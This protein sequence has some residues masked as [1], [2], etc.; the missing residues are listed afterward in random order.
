MRCKK[1]LNAAL[2][3]LAGVSA[4]ASVQCGAGQ[5]APGITALAL[6]GVEISASTGEKPQSKVWSHAGHWWAVLPNAAGTHL[7]RL[8]G[9]HWTPALHLSD[10]TDFHADARNVNG[11]THVFLYRATQSELVSLEY[12]SAA[13]TYRLW[14]MRPAPVPIHLD[15]GVETA[16]IDVDA[17]G[18][19]WLASDGVTDINVRWSDPPYAEW[20]APLTLA[21][22]VD[23]DDICVVTAFPNGDTGVLWSNQ[24]TK[25]FGFRVHPAG[26]APAAWSPDEAPASASALPVGDGMPDDHLNCAIAAE[27]TLYVA[28][29]TSYDTEGYTKIGL[30]LRRPSGEWD[31]LHHVD[32]AGT[33][34]IALLNEER[35][36]LFVVY[37]LSDAIVYR[38]SSLDAIAFG[39]RQT[40]ITK[41]SERVN[42]VTSTKQNFIGEVVILGSTPTTAEGV[43]LTLP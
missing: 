19:M 30:L 36:L 37:N 17:S 26:E 40:L 35:G 18:G 16:T 11:V 41:Q 28:V 43:K 3:V 15:P 29:K 5:T 42:N 6:Q 32:D 1:H 33:R 34:P 21:S 2:V 24:N 4:W 39:P 9:T 14:S 31:D 13:N 20:S 38:Q 22:G 27:G 25:R 23:E 7:W 12:D 8:D 10:A